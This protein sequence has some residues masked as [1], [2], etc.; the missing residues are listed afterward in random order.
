MGAKVLKFYVS[1]TDVV[2]HQSVYESIA[3]A[4]KRYGM[5]GVT[6]YKGIMGYGSSSVLHSDKFWEFNQKIPLV[7][8]IVDDE[9]KIRDFLDKIMPWIEMLPKG[10]LV[11]VQDVEV[12]LQKKGKIK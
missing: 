6:I 11:T 9:Q 10:C 5:S 12:I 2:K 7:V 1:N 4:A 3:F 8:E